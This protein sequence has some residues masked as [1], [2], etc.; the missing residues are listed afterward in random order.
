[1]KTLTS[2]DVLICCDKNPDTRRS[3]LSAP[4]VHREISH[5]QHVEHV[6]DVL[7]D[8]DLKTI[9]FIFVD[10]SVLTS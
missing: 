6:F 10:C 1:M 4:T 5:Q 2:P 7:F 3:G 8:H 9:I